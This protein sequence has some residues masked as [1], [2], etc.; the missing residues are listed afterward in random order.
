M[1]TSNKLT[2]L[3]VAALAV[4]MAFPAQAAEFPCRTAKLIVPW[5]A[6]GGTGVIFRLVIETVNKTGIK[7]QLQM[8]NISGQG[9]NK[10]A[11]VARKAKPDGCTLFAIHQSALSSYLTG[12][13]KF[14]W[15]AFEPI[16]MLTRTSPI[17]GANKNVPWKDARDLVKAAKAKP[18]SILTGGTLGS[19]SHFWFLLLEEATGIKLK[20]VSYDGTRQR[21]TALLGGHIQIG[22]INLAAAVKYIQAGELKALGIY[23]EK[24]HPLAPNVPTMREMGIDLVTGTDRG[25]SAPKGTSKEKVAFWAK[26][27]EKAA[28]DKAL[29]ATLARKGTTISFKGPAAS[30]A[31]WKETFTKW[32]GIATKI[33]MYKGG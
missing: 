16:A 21:M 7:P 6:G 5:G 3:A 20:H 2:A 28:N 12:R 25:V 8:V 19:T 4:V 30:T 9:G 24:R 22:E 29:I 17:I 15:D 26:V 13:V 23:T 27:F 11:K 33:G 14:T 31:Y 18:G 10:G 32:K 1:K